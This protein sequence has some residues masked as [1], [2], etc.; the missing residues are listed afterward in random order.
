MPRFT[1]SGAK[2]PTF[3]TGCY[4]TFTALRAM[5]SSEGRESERK[6]PQERSD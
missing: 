5:S 6:G 2:R 4:L 3:T 1:C